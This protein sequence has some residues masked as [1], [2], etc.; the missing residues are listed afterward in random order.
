MHAVNVLI[1][2]DD[3]ITLTLL[4]HIVDELVS[5]E[6]LV[7]SSS[8]KA[9]AFLLTEDAQRIDLVICDWQM[10]SVS[11]IKILE[12]LRSKSLNCPFLMIT[13]IPTKDL[14]ISAKR[15]GV[16]DFIAKPFSS[17]DLTQKLSVLLDKISQA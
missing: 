11:G 16:T 13:A 15:L 7:F 14:V 8:I 1:I 9:N 4:E 10:P 3:D 12:T 5:G 6:I 2:D 17:D